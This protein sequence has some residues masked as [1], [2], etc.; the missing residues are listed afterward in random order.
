M[1]IAQR[2]PFPAL[3]ATLAIL[4]A[5]AA[6]AQEPGELIY[7]AR[8]AM[9]HDAADS[10]APSREAL[11]QMSVARIIRTM[12]F[13]AMMSVTLKFLALLVKTLPCYPPRRGVPH[14]KITKTCR[15]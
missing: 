15:P 2:S 7:A 12:D 11:R 4:W 14:M 8:C 1:E 9:C 3:I 10:R 13:G 5:G 6:A